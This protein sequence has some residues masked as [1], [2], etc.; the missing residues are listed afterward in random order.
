MRRVALAW[1]IPPAAVFHY[2]G[3]SP[4]AAPIAVFWLAGL[5]SIAYGLTGGVAQLGRTSWLEVLLG[6]ALWAIA[7]AWA[8]LVIRGVAHDLGTDA[9]GPRDHRVVPA[10]DEPDPLRMTDRSGGHP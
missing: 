9:R 8:R 4:T 7:A 6:F 2:G 1:W 10:E 5:G 3:A